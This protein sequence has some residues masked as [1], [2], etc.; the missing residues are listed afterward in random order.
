M[1]FNLEKQIQEW[2]FSA[3][4]TDQKKNLENTF[5]LFTKYLLSIGTTAIVSRGGGG[6]GQEAE[7]YAVGNHYSLLTII[8]PTCSQCTAWNRNSTVSPECMNCQIPQR[9]RGRRQRP[10][11][12]ISNKKKCQILWADFSCSYMW[13]LTEFID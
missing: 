4:V 2:R 7:V 12:K 5:H 3:K 8:S 11:G 10:S 6:V 1:K 9:S 13:P